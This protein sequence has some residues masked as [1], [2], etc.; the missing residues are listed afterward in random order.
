MFQQ[1]LFLEIGDQDLLTPGLDDGAV[2]SS[3]NW[4][5]I[6]SWSHDCFININ[7]Y[8]ESFSSP[9]SLMLLSFPFLPFVKT[10]LKHVV[11]ELGRAKLWRCTVSSLVILTRGRCLIRLASSWDWIKLCFSPWVVGMATLLEWVLLIF[12]Y[13]C[14]RSW[15]WRE[16]KATFCIGTWPLVWI[17]NDYFLKY[18]KISWHG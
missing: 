13:I 4:L 7:R 11:I 16:A 2:I 9:S 10:R 14:S 8:F 3:W 1:K 5:L 15:W 17:L 18:N 6:L 12:S